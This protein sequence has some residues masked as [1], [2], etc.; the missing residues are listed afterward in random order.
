MSGT[1][2]TLNQK[3]NN[4]KTQSEN[5][6]GGGGGG[7]PTTSD[8]ADILLNGNSAGASD[9][10][11]NNQDILQVD[12]IDLTTING[13][14]YPPRETVSTTILTGSANTLTV[15]LFRYYTLLVTT[16]MVL[17]I[18]TADASLLGV[19]FTLRRGLGSNTNT[20]AVTCSVA[21]MARSVAIGV[22]MLPTNTI[23]STY[24]C[25]LFGSSPDVYC[26]AST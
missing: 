14:E 13:S 7:G 16:N 3:Y 22:E 4:L 11:L 15:P 8:L 23:F 10:D 20:T 25:V 6:G 9:I 2:F 26:W 1:F 24:T 17:T 19:S 18:P 5:N 12:N 21:Q